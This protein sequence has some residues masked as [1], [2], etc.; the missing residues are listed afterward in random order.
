MS[1]STMH[2]MSRHALSALVSLGRRRHLPYCY[3]ITSSGGAHCTMTRSA[4]WAVAHSS[5]SA[6]VKRLPQDTWDSHMH[7][8]EPKK[9][10][11][12]SSATYIPEAHTLEEALLFESSVGMRNIVLVQPSIYG[13]DNSLI[14]DV[15]RKLGPDRARGVVQF[16]PSIDKKTLDD[17][18]TW[19]VRGVRLNV[20]STGQEVDLDEFAARL[21]THANIIRPYGWVLEAFISLSMLTHLEAT[22]RDLGVPFCI[23]HFGM[24][25]AGKQITDIY[26][27]PGYA[28]LIRL[29]EGGDTWVKFSGDYRVGV[30][31]QMLAAAA[32]EI[33]RVRVDRA[34]FATDWPH[35]RFAGLDI[36]PFMQRC[37]EWCE[38]FN[39]EDAVFS[40][41]AKVLWGVER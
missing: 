20:H 1:M 17:W 16:E 13:S 27:I 10:P 40:S 18:H 31:E 37:L 33:L 12:A 15:L 29:I 2:S 4:P 24:P 23:A 5:T 39:C 34:V 19:G 28:S 6:F 9:Y 21:K 36:Q 11:L 38:E 22:I 30:S 3:S 14:L 26:D 8:V 32:K 35:T 7:V 25:K 41:N